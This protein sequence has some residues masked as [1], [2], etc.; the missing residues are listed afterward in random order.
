MNMK[1]NITMFKPLP[2]QYVSLKVLTEDVPLVAQVL[3]DCGMFNPETTEMFA[4]QLP[5]HPG[6]KFHSVF[7]LARS[8]FDKILARIPFTPSTSPIHIIELSKLENINTQLGNIWQVLSQLEEQLH[9]CN[10]QY[11]SFKQLLET[12]KTFSGLDVDLK[13]FQDSAKFLNL[14]IGTVSV[15]NIEHLQDSIGLAA[16]F[17]TIFQR[18]EHTVSFVVAGP[19][20]HQD[21]IRAILEHADFQALSIPPEFHSHPQKVHADLTSK[22][23]ELQIQTDTVKT[24]INALA[25]K[26]KTILEQAYQTLNSAAAYAKLTETFRCHGQL[27]LIEGWMPTADLSKLESALTEKLDSPF[28]FNTRKPSPSEY[29]HVPSL[30]RHH[31]LLA[32]FIALVKNYGTPRYG[33]FDPTLLFSITFILMFGTMFGDVGHGALIAGAGWYWREK[34]TIFTPFFIA[35]GLSSIFFGFLYGSI[36]GFEE[37]LLPALWMSPI[38]NPNLMLTVALYWGIGFILLATLL[39]VINRWQEGEY[40][41]ALLNNTGIAGIFLYLGGFYAVRKWMESD[42]FEIDQQLALL[43]PLLLILGYKWYKNKLPFGERFLVTLIEGLESIINYLANTL[44][45]LR[46]AAFSLNHA[47]LA[48]AVF[49]LANMMESPG[50]WVVIILGNLF[51]VIVEGAIVTIQVLRLEYYEGFSRFFSGDGRAFHPLMMGLNK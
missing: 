25:E 36:F 4:E 26:N 7:N 29:P 16:H 5:E 47:A 20:E 3:A 32:P 19:L 46:V 15:D 49:T 34:L 31:R 51:I 45:F 12:L 48:I 38:H 43:L 17:I 9:Q 14:H 50:N 13:I 35:A 6:K 1:Q 10:E 42:L 37:I 11:T 23:E 18:D 22:I 8:R 2:M 27:A 33:E 30:I 41:A 40:A 39:T 24:T 21:K 44:S 28:V